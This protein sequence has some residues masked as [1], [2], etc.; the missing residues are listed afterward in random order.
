MK[1][2]E[3]KMLLTLKR[4]FC[5]FVYQRALPCDFI[6]LHYISYF[7]VMMEQC[8]YNMARPNFIRNLFQCSIVKLS[9]ILEWFW[10]VSVN[11]GG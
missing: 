1:S 10:I 6:I 4:F 5:K 8:L 2:F 3:S 11:A 7:V 9:E